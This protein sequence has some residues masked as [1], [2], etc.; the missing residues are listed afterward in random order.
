MRLAIIVVSLLA[1]AEP[2]RPQI[3]VTGKTPPKAT[4]AGTV[5]KEPGGEP[6]RKAVV[7]LIAEDQQEAGNFT[8][9]SDPDGHFSI[10]EIPPGRYHLFVERPG[11]IEVDKQQRR[12]QGVA[13]SFD[14]GETVKDQSLHMLPAAVVMGRVLD[15]DGDPMPNAEVT[16]WQRKF[17]AR[18]KFESAGGTQTNDLG[19]YR[20]GGLL[21]GKY[22]LSASPPVNFQ[23]LVP[24]RKTSD[25]SRVKPSDTAYVTTYFP[26]AIDRAQA[27]A[28]E[29]HPG[30]EMPVDFTLSRIHTE[31]IRGSVSGLD[32]RAKAVVMLRSR[33]THAMFVG[34]E[35]DKAGKFEVAR[36]TPGEYTVIVTTI[37]EERPRTGFKDIE[38]A[39]SDIE[40]LRLSISDGATIRGKIH[41]A[42]KA[43]PREP[44]LY[45]SL[46]RLDGEQD[47][48]EDMAMGA[49]V[50]G[51]STFSKAKPDDS[52]ELKNVPAG[53]YE[54][55]IAGD[56][57]EMGNYFVASV[58][59][60][61]QET[62][63]SGLN[64]NGGTL[65]IDVTLSAGAGL[66]EGSVLNEKKDP[67]ANAV[68]V[69]VP[70]MKYRKRPGYYR[71]N[72]SDQ[73]GRFS[74]RNLRPG[75]YTLYAWELLDGEEYLDADFLKQ[76]EGKGVEVEVE[77]FSRQTIP[78][79]A[80]T[81]GPD[82]P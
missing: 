4:L 55:D 74:L 51:G 10:G 31:R 72:S 70:E 6:I 48:P 36:V 3:S 40:D 65:A 63:E 75:H 14:A 23:S 20:I 17:G 19:E 66:V 45:T 39:D 52:F 7:E 76:F 21:A 28:L 41:W 81:A 11:Y 27:S 54:I 49:E 35:V 46:H 2:G 58:T 22:Y 73:Q 68:V 9:T 32:S 38:V 78:M 34:G 82:Q 43:T 80:I 64:V 5:V 56:S 26:N 42:S 12:S 25:T 15:E 61:T 79:K 1:I 30:D 53:L 24:E 44:A 33:D 71:K 50:G 59:A 67:V 60:G 16:L 29:L 8:A 62:I 57:K 69:A 13:L 18:A 47:S 37:D 77:K